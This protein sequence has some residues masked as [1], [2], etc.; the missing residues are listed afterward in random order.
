[1]DPVNNRVVMSDENRSGL[2]IYDRA[3]GSFL[4]DITSDRE[5]DALY[6]AIVVDVRQ[7]SCVRVREELCLY[8][9]G[10]SPL[11]CFLVCS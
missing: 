11:G 7:K 4:K 2:F 6:P 8:N 10:I 3:A 1:V 9:A 5:R